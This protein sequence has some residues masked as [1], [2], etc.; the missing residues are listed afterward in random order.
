MYKY[1]IGEWFADNAIMRSYLDEVKFYSGTERRKMLNVPPS[2]GGS[3]LYG[4][5][6][7]GYLAPGRTRTPSIYPKLYKTKVMDDYPELE[8]IFKEFASIYFPAFKWGQ[9]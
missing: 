1:F 2:I 4:L 3:M 9:V 7:R 6:W 8:E 5:T